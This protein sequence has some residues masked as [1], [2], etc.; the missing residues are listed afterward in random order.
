MTLPTALLLFVIAIIGG[1]VNSVAGG[2][3]FFTLP[4]LIFAGV[5]AVPANA[6]ST[7]AL[8]PASLA[9]AGAYRK[10]LKEMNR[11]LLI[12]LAVTSLIGGILGAILLIKT[13]S[14]FFEV[15]LP[16]LLLFATVLFAFSPMITA[17]LRLRK[18]EKTE[19][20]PKNTIVISL[21]Q[22]IIAVYGGY[23]GGGIGIMML[24]SLGIMGMD[25]IHAMNA[26]K[27]LL[28][29]IINGIAVVIFIAYGIIYWPQALVMIVGS[30]IGGY[31]S[32]Y[33]ARKIDQKYIRAFVIVVGVVLSILFF[34]KR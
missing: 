13:P 1:T 28:T 14:S 5:P 33:Y 27:N 25:N 19:M 29:S 24:A 31:G 15:L 17:R 20:T 32:S 4:T 34:F 9:S 11:S 30:I 7:I 8:W 12:V 3:S 23:F 21:V 16:Y 22:L 2:G 6:T 10:E 18:L 26:V